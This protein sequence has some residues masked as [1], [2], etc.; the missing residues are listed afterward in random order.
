MTGLG[1]KEASSS[2]DLSDCWGA[3]DSMEVAVTRTVEGRPEVVELGW[4][5]V[6]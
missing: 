6:S 3:A 1:R 5:A 2:L 4:I